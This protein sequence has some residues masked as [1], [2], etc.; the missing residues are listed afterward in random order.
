M[1]K[2]ILIAVAGGLVMLL[3]L[4]FALTVLISYRAFFG[5]AITW[6]LCA[7]VAALV[8][9]V[10]YL[11]IRYIVETV[12]KRGSDEDELTE[13]HIEKMLTNGESRRSEPNPDHK[14]VAAAAAAALAAPESVAAADGTTADAGAGTTLR[15]ADILRAEAAAREAAAQ[16]PEPNTEGGAGEDHTGETKEETGQEPPPTAETPATDTETADAETTPQT[17]PEPQAAPPAADI[18]RTPDD[19]RRRMAEAEARARQA[20]AAAQG[21]RERA[22]REAQAEE[23]RRASEQVQ[24]ALRHSQQLAQQPRPT[25]AHKRPEVD[26]VRRQAEAAAAARRRAAQMAARSQSF[27]AIK[28]GGSSSAI[29][30]PTPPVVAQA[31]A[32]PAPQV[33]VHTGAPGGN[34]STHGGTMPPAPEQ[35]ARVRYASDPIPYESSGDD[36]IWD[37]MEVRRSAAPLL[38][39][40]YDNAGRTGGPR[41]ADT[42]AGGFSAGRYATTELNREEVLRQANLAAR[43]Q[44]A[45]PRPQAAQPPRPQQNPPP[46]PR[47][48]QPAQTAQAAS[49]FRLESIQEN[50]REVLGGNETPTTASGWKYAP[51]KPPRA[52]NTNGSSRRI[53]GE[54]SSPAGAAEAPDTTAHAP[55]QAYP[56]ADS[57]HVKE[58]MQ[59]A[60]ER[61]TAARGAAVAHDAAARPETPRSEYHTGVAPLPRP[62][63]GQPQPPLAASPHPSTPAPDTF[64]GTVIP[65]A[66]GD[67]AKRPRGRPPKPKTEE[68]LNAPKRPRGRPPKPKTEEELN[69]PKRPRGRPRKN[70]L[71][72]EVSDNEQSSQS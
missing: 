40:R 59:R 43:S 47:T 14:A 57:D 35:P 60:N 20:A 7:C 56:R 17:V 51:A 31:T 32:Q 65:L 22:S 37:R 34:S 69:A 24:A 4:L 42:H 9:F 66:E 27:P 64:A 1:V 54:M 38:T 48:A 52:W 63:A 36:T 39:N 26:S 29:G 45:A 10:I 19:H 15:P 6:V 5:T 53:P 55:R 61:A 13:V 70:P 21:A 50:M 33:P 16:K 62:T 58:A 41:P 3:V 2:K 71:P 25:D 8:V 12:R 46:R 67:D 18:Q 30:G 72:E 23:Q 49:G 68:E 44:P 28:T 11:V